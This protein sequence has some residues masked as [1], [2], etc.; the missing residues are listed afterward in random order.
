MADSSFFD[1]H[2]LGE[3]LLLRIKPEVKWIDVRAA[4]EIDKQ[5]SDLVARHPGV[6]LLFNLA[7]V[8]M[9]ATIMIGNLVRLQKLLQEREAVVKLC[10]V[11]ESVRKTLTFMGLDKKF[12]IEDDEAAVL[13]DEVPDAPARSEAVSPDSPEAQD[14]PESRRPPRPRGV[15]TL[16]PADATSTKLTPDR[17]EDSGAAREAAAAA[18]GSGEP[19]TGPLSERREETADQDTG[20][21]SPG[22]TSATR[23]HPELPLGLEYPAP[24]TVVISMRERRILNARL[25]TSIFQ[26]LRRTVDSGEYR[27]VIIDLHEVR[28]ISST[29]LGQILRLKESLGR[30]S[31]RLALCG[32]PEDHR[33]LLHILSGGQALETYT[34]KAEALSRI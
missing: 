31:G 21:K 9:M 34:D 1:H 3:V 33:P 25:V 8:E 29:L 16:D 7:P 28:F 15:L 2:L 17:S 30:S 22:T 20:P 4:N 5:V 11:T 19:G 26:F 18:A 32:V 12:G 27:N 10:H 14:A 24:G 6:S 13:G 23:Q